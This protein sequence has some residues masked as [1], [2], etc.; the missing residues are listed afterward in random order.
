MYFMLNIVTGPEEY[1]AAV[2]MRGGGDIVG[3]GRLTKRLSIDTALNTKK[4]DIASGLW[5]EDRGV[6]I[7]KSAIVRTPRI[8]I[9]SAGPVW[10]KKPYR[11]V[12]KREA[13]RITRSA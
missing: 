11:F 5:I 2:L 6:V 8:G 9:D 7:P 13:L 1:P 10:V 12:L 3:P 4:A